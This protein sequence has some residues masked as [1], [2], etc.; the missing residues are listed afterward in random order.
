VAGG[1]TATSCQV[2]AVELLE[3]SAAAAA[4]AACGCVPRRSNGHDGR[5]TMLCISLLRCNNGFPRC[6]R[7]LAPFCWAQGLVR[8]VVPKF[9]AGICRGGGGPSRGRMLGW[10]YWICLVGDAI[11]LP[12]LPR[13]G[14]YLGMR[15]AARCRVG[16]H[17]LPDRDS[18]DAAV[19]L[20]FR[21]GSGDRGTDGDP[22]PA[23]RAGRAATISVIAQRNAAAVTADETTTAGT[24]GHE[25]PARRRWYNDPIV[26]APTPPLSCMCFLLATPTE[27]SDDGSVRLSW[28]PG[29]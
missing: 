16:H 18:L 2:Q 11:T 5:L 13:K 25:G 8:G 27:I 9:P 29:I 12:A 6:I 10:E 3:H 1:G 7:S 28:A 14:R 15:P 17:V 4:A 20:P 19:S 22:L 26:P 21:N 23:R 24:G